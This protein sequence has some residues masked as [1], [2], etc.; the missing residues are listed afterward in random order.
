MLARPSTPQALTL[1]QATSS[2]TCTSRPRFFRPGSSSGRSSPAGPPRSLLTAPTSATSPAPARY[3]LLSTPPRDCPCMPSSRRPPTPPTCRDCR[4]P[5]V[6]WTSTTCSA[7]CPGL[8]RSAWVRSLPPRCWRAI[9]ST[10]PRFA[11]TRMPASASTAT[12]LKPRRSTWTHSPPPASSMITPASLPRTSTTAC[13]VAL[14]AFSSM[15]PAATTCAAL[16]AT[17]W[18][19]TSTR[20][21]CASASTTSAWWRSSA[22]IWA[23][24]IAWS[25]SL[26]TRACRPCRPSRW[27]R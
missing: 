6:R 21:T 16:S 4:P 22:R 23:T 9:P 5:A 2:R 24:W 1:S 12:R 14:P 15:R 11:P 26:W 7:C 13:G 25:P 18:T 3:A 20:T 19:S 8:K 10:W 17:S 27:P